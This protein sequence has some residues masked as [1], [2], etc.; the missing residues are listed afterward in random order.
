MKL[1]RKARLYFNEGKSDKV[2]EVDLCE[3]H[4]QQYVVNF[5]YGRRGNSLREGTKTPTPVDR[6]TADEVFESI[7]VSKTN[8]GYKDCETASP[9]SNE[10]SPPPEIAIDQSDRD[11]C[12]VSKLTSAISKHQYN[13]LSRLVWRIGELGISSA[14]PYLIKIIGQG[15]DLLDYCT[16]WAL[17]RCQAK[18]Y[19]EK[20]EW[21][22]KSSSNDTVRRIS[23][24]ASLHLLDESQRKQK[25][26]ELVQGLPDPIKLALEH[27]DSENLNLLIDQH[28]QHNKKDVAFILIT[29]YSLA[30]I[31]QSAKQVLNRLINEIPLKPK[32]FKGIRHIFKLSEFRRDSI[33]FGILAYRFETEKSPFNIEG[34][35][36]YVWIPEARRYLDY[37]KEVIKPDPVVAYSSKTQNYLRRRV[38]RTLK[39]LGDESSDSYIDLASGVLHQFNDSDAKEERRSEVYQWSNSGGRWHRELIRTT[40]YGAYANYL[41]FNQIIY[42]N[43]KQYSLT[44][45]RNAWA[46][47]NDSSTRGGREEAYPQ[48]WDKHP[49]AL[50]D[51]LLNSRCGP[52]HHFAATAL[53][54]NY[55]FYSKISVTDLV[56]LLEK[57]Y[58]T[59]LH[60]ALAIA[61]I[62]YNPDNPDIDLIQGLLL[63]NLEEARAI[64]QTWAAANPQT[65]INNPEAI[66]LILFSSHGDTR[67][68][69]RGFLSQADTSNLNTDILISRIVAQIMSFNEQDA[70][71][72]AVIED[73]TWTLINVFPDRIKDIG[74]SI[75]LDLLNHPLDK[76]QAMGGRLLL[77]RLSLNDNAK[78]DELS[79]DLFQRLIKASSAEVRSIGVQL[80]GKLSDEQLLVQSELLVEFCISVDTPVRESVGP[81]V[82]RLSKRDKN[83]GVSLIKSIIPVLFRQEPQDDYHSGIIKLITNRLSDCLNSIDLDQVWRLL[84]AKSKGAQTFGA[85]LLDN[86]AFDKFS[87]RQLAM[88]G[89]SPVKKVRNWICLA[90]E[91]NPDYFRQDPENA[92]LLLNSDWEDMRESAKEFFRNHFDKT[93]W[94]PDLLISI[95]DNVLDDIQRFGR[96]LVTEFFEDG[97]GETYLLKLSQHPTNQVQLFATNYLEGYASDKPDRIAKL[98]NYFVTVLS[99]VNKARITKNRI[100]KFLHTESMKS[101]EVALVASSIF[102]RQS[103]TIGIIDKASY[104]EAMRDI[105]E[106]HPNITLPI[107][108]IPVSQR[109][110]ANGV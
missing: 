21:L 5:R 53:K 96:E 34:Y 92:L 38:A 43:S 70:V 102:T 50:L 32:Y 28:L 107:K 52:V 93:I 68:W 74:L 103:V 48:L 27:S 2:Y 30:L 55:Q 46:K 6:A 17:G 78:P 77:N 39:R 59:T 36:S 94:T 54:A 45:G 23:Y 91:Q 100:I 40:E 71:L 58:E 89:N 19:I 7:V 44:S 67:S 109:G 108:R 63:A 37:N 60:L 20:I 4:N 90:L 22:S 76:V 13:K 105:Q 8:K 80:L 64:A 18:E 97:D 101:K 10:S 72:D 11:A 83:F 3:V 81:I 25:L 42:S 16:I 15:D 88:L 104:I 69:I 1:V 47:T 33:V 65:L 35:S 98:E 86:I 73:I 56:A 57:P 41:A 85:C 26:D 29:L 82:E 61:Q 49:Q 66:V 95:C 79:P 87:V 99:Q 110:A 9:P 31:N 24:E 14:N 75:I 62:R 51:L 106:L 84:R 12:L